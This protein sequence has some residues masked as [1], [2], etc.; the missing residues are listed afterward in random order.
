VIVETT[1]SLKGAGHFTLWFLVGVLIFWLAKAA[2]PQAT[3]I[4]LWGPFL[5][6]L[7]AS[8]AIVPYLLQVT[9]FIS[10]ETALNC[11]FAVFLLYP[12]TEEAGWARTLFGHFHF[13]VVLLAL[14]YSSLVSH[15]IRFVKQLRRSH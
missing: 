4:S 11:G 5:P 3:R 13:N 9:G 14:A 8:V 7:L 15:Y 6:F 12:L 1:E 2:K 10:R